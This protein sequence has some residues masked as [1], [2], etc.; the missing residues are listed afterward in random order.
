M[1]TFDELRPRLIAIAYRMLGSASEADDVVQDS[2]LR[3]QG[4]DRSDVRDP[5]AWLATTVSRLCIDRLTSARAKREAYTG[6]WLPEPVRTTC[7]VDVESIALGFLVLLERLSPIE[8]AVF[9]LHRSFDFSHAEIAA[10]LAISEDA[11]RQALHR[12]AAHVAANKPR[13]RADRAAH[14]RLLGAFLGALATGDLDRMRALLAEDATLYGDG[15]GKVPR[16]ILR[17]I[18]GA[19]RIARLFVGFVAKTPDV[20]AIAVSIEEINGT[21]AV[22]GRDPVGVRFVLTFETD[23]EVIHVVRN[24][25]NPDKLA[26]PRF[27]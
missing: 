16:A 24:I 12:A 15:G 3:W 4:A 7:P 27:D 25:L 18:H 21:P 14:E 11:S 9:V 5:G 22:V 1:L 8:R 20:A 17:P 10:T 19:D 6:T 23:G 2:W 26:L 13:F